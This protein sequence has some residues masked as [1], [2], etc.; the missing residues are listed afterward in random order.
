MALKRAP[1][2]KT[3][4]ENEQACEHQHKDTCLLTFSPECQIGNII[5][6]RTGPV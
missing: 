4:L 2:A 3:V 5:P 6:R 1:E